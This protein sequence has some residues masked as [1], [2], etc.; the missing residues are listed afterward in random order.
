MEEGLSIGVVVHTCPG[1][2]EKTRGHAEAL[3]Q[4][5]QLQAVPGSTDAL[6]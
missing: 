1:K 5:T 2:G 3:S 4:H 6:S